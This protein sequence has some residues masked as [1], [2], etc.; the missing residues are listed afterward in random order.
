MS[1]VIKERDFT[2]ILRVENTN[3]DGRRKLPYALTAIKGI[4]VRL[5]T[6]A[7]KKAG[8]DPNKR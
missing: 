7:C 1:L 6:I 8:L 2:H 5:A 3:V 4:G